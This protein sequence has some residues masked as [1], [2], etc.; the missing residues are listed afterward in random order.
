MGGFN[1]GVI[2]GDYYDGVVTVEATHDCFDI[3]SHFHNGI[4]MVSTSL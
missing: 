3:V 4:V 2:V 1:D